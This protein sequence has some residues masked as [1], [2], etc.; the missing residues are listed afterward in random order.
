MGPL[1]ADPCTVR[2]QS[3]GQ[4]TESWCLRTL[5]SRHQQADGEG[6]SDVRRAQEGGGLVGFFSA[7]SLSLVL[8]AV[9]ASGLLSEQDRN[10]S[11]RIPLF[12]EDVKRAS[13]GLRVLGEAP[14]D[15]VLPFLSWPYSEASSNHAAAAMAVVE[16]SKTPR[17]TI[18]LVGNWENRPLCP[19]EFGGML[20]IF[21]LLPISPKNH[22]SYVKLQY[23][24]GGRM[25][26]R[27]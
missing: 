19:N 4:N 22:P 23:S 21:F 9:R 13:E 16:A 15:P 25:K 11:E 6:K 17:R 10:N 27:F 8:T 7:F 2:T 18:S 1:Q 3:S 26:L 5:T 12:P 20:L 24:T 14:G